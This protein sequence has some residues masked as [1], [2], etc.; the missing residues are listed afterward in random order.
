MKLNW[1]MLLV[2]VIPASFS[3]IGNIYQYTDK[4]DTINLNYRQVANV[5]EF[6]NRLC[7]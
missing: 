5:A 7:K 4:Q 6:Y 3:L 1:N 2:A